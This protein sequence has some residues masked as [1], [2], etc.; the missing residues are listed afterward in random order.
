MSLKLILSIP[1]LSDGATRKL[2]T[3]CASH[4]IFSSGGIVIECTTSIFLKSEIFK[5]FFSANIAEVEKGLTNLFY[6]KKK[7][8]LACSLNEFISTTV[9]VAQQ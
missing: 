3:T 2:K 9:N 5:K 1:Y 6:L 7:K 8:N 4:F